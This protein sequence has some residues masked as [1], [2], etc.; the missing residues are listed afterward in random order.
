M[1]KNQRYLPKVLVTDFDRTLTCLYKNSDLLIDLA[2]IIS[3]HYKH[4]ISIPSRLLDGKSDGYFVWHELHRRAS[5]CLPTVE[6]NEINAKAEELVTEFELAIIKSIGLFTEVPASVHKLHKLGIRLGIVSSNATYVVRYALEQAKIADL[7]E[8]IAGRPH[9]FQPELV[10]PNP[11]PINCA[12][13]I[14]NVEREG[15]CYVGDDIIDM[16]AA[17]SAGVT[18]IGVASGKYSEDELMKG[19][20]Q[21]CFPSFTDMVA[22]FLSV[23]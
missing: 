15:F 12:L 10:K 11:Y 9:P 5:E 6:A 17:R 1:D 23:V 7:F 19:G 2:N 8:Y 21:Y 4:N 18:A 16:K 3:N 22:Y 13:D 14:M 20:A